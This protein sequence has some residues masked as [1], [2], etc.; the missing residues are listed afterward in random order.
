MKKFMLVLSLTFTLGA[1]ITLTSC[2]KE[3]GG[4]ADD[5]VSAQD[6]TSINNAVNATADDAA[7]AAGQ[8]KSFSGKTDGWWNSAVLCGVQLV[9]S[10]TAGNRVI[11]LTYDGTTTCNGVVRSGTVTI[12]NN[13]GLPWKEAGSVLNVVF[14][15]L[16]I[17]DPVT[18]ATF[19]VN[20][21]HTFT[22]ETAG[23]EW[24]V[25]AGLT[26]NTTVTRRNV[27]NMTISF[28]NGT[29]RTWTVDRTRS[30]SS[31][32]NANVNTIT[33]SIY[34]EAAGGVDVT[35]TNRFGNTFTNTIVQPIAANNN[36]GCYWKPYTGK[37]THSV[38]SRTATV[39]FGTDASGNQI[40]SPTT[41]GDGYYITYTNNNRTVYK[42][43]GY[44]H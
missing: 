37:I 35:G 9:D 33:V 28:P 8:V 15:N 26:T 18:L 39:L 41:C 31:V 23:L 27:G 14:N 36:A 38:S 42:F 12:T 29:T 44:W 11:T 13:S 7:A 25:I 2:Q 3:K 43:V 30:W 17:T 4:A 10:G 40:G 34:S 19:T 32:V 20:G 5:S 21:T 16:Q 24:Q 1:A 6:N 22:K